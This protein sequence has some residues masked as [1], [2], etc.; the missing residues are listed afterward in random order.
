MIKSVDVYLWGTHIGTLFQ[1]EDD[2][3]AGF[4]Y[5]SSFIKSGIELSPFKMPLSDSVYSFSE[6]ARIDSFHGLPG[7]IADSLPDRFGNAVIN[8][9]LSITGHNPSEFTALDRLCYTGKR[10]MGALEY[11]PSNGPDSLNDEINVSEMVSFASDIIQNKGSK[12]YNEENVTKA[13]LIDIGSSA[14]GARAKAVIA[15]N[16]ETGSVRSGQIEAG[17]GYDYW[18]IKFDGIEGNG[19]H[20]EEDK[21]QYT[22]IEYAYYLMALD[23]GIEMNDCRI[24]EKDGLYHFMT[25]R[26]DRMNGDKI[27]MQTLAA[28]GHFDYNT[29]G[30]C[31][32]ELYS[33]FAREL[34]IGASGIEQIFR[35][36]VFSDLG[37][38]YDDHV[39][40]F[41]FLMNRQGGW[42]L[43]PAYD[44][45]FAYVPGNRW[46]S[47]HQMT[48]NGK[49]ID[50]S[51]DDLI[52]C[53][54]NMGLNVRK[55]KNI[56]EET[57]HIISKW[58]YY[59]EKSHITEKRAEEIDKIIK[60]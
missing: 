33:R 54:T 42:R 29:P 55:C 21:K 22:L 40:N 17:K 9:W 4:E 24:F 60:Y 52:Q 39:K 46:I 47:R 37:K 51:D 43:S 31:S 13:Q 2:I 34:G 30:E 19:D 25:K 50:I 48:I 14:G 20:G 23:L 27:H 3:V 26:F 12:D 5:D 56:I 1:G 8:N 58:M 15:W 7:L 36:M 10:G 53:G 41:S 38:N 6:L 35:R 11:M 49:S 18:I 57:K 28:L 44:I 45:C 32:Y 16:E 59:A